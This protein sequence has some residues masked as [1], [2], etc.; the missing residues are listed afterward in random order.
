MKSYEVTPYVGVGDLKFGMSPSIAEALLGKPKLSDFDEDT[1][2][3]T[4]YW[5]NN[6]L[7]L[8]FSEN[9]NRLVSISMYSN[10]NNIQLP[11]IP[12]NWANSKS[13]YDTLIKLDPSA[14]QTVGITVFFKYG[15]AVTGFRED[16]DGSK[17]ITAFDK[18]Q[19][20]Q[21]DPYLKPLILDHAQ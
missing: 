10:I 8:T 19:W 20:T 15:I 1:G 6:G 4:Q 9:D 16:E 3:T 21:E 18:G 2:T 12:F 7:Q 13:T 5:E 11:G 17:S 14:R